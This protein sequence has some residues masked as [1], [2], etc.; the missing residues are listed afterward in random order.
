MVSMRSNLKARASRRAN[1]TP[2]LDLE[3]LG[4]PPAAHTNRRKHDADDPRGSG[5]GAV[6]AHARVPVDWSMQWSPRCTEPHESA[7][8]SWL[9]PARVTAGG[10][11]PAGQGPEEASA[12]AAVGSPISTLSATATSATSPSPPRALPEP[13]GHEPAAARGDAPRS[14]PPEDES[15]ERDAWTRGRSSEACRP[16]CGLLAAMRAPNCAVTLPLH[17]RLLGAA[18]PVLPVSRVR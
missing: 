8:D 3:H 2:E 12:G 11:G 17:S 15:P 9:L 1:T 4:R 7:V 5:G 6:A 10:S 14:A 16:D 13:P 18:L